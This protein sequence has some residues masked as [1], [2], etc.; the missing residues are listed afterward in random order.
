MTAPDPA[1]P[2]PIDDDGYKPRPVLSV[3]FWVVIA[4]SGLGP[5]LALALVF[6]TP[7]PPAAPV[8][9][10]AIAQNPTL[11]VKPKER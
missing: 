10:A 8:H 3:T 11:G 1:A 9:S 6:F 4:F 7:H 2:A 5:L